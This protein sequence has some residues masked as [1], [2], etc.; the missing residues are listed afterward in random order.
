MP[1]NVQLVSIST[2]TRS[3]L[4]A[5]LKSQQLLLDL[6][7]RHGAV[8][9]VWVQRIAV[10]IDDMGARQDQPVVVRLVAVAV[11]QEDVAGLHQR[12]ADDL[13]GGRGAVGDEI[14]APGA[15]GARRQLLRLL[16][17][18]G[19][20]QQ[21]IEPAARSPRS[22]QGRCSCRRSWPMSWIQWDLVIDLPR[23]IGMAWNTPVG[24]RL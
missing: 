8:H 1:S 18:A 2:L 9:R 4:P 7:Q 14:G 15:E 21:R 6:A 10:E 24:W 16:D 13:V 11:D 5:R 22:P 20:L 17:R 3:S 12:L 23:L 19:R